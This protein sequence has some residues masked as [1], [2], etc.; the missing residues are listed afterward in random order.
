MEQGKIEWERLVLKKMQHTLSAEEQLKLEQISRQDPRLVE[1]I[2]RV[3]ME[4]GSLRLRKGMQGHSRWVKLSE[5]IQRDISREPTASQAHF[6]RAWYFAAAAAVLIFLCVYLLI[7]AS[8]MEVVVAEN[9]TRVIELP[10]H[11]V[12]TLNNGAMVKYDPKAWG[13]DRKI[14]L[15]GEAFFDVRRNGISFIVTSENARVSVLGTTFNIRTQ[16]EETAVSCLTGRVSVSSL[17]EPHHAAMLTKGL[18]VT[19]AGSK[20]SEVHQLPTMNETS[21]MTG[22]LHFD[23][24]PVRDVFNDLERHFRKRIILKRETGIKTFTGKF[25]EPEFK[26][27]M[28]TVCLSAGLVCTFSGDSVIVK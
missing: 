10:D 16:G 8:K 1:E 17:K 4:A 19:V 9:T 11:S 26:V 5:R 27:A 3:W 7:P 25:K 6:K 12:V 21:W 28:E 18:G 14:F 22:N 24:A 2:E 13:Q 20:L 15:T 23:N